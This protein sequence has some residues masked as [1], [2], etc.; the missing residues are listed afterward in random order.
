[1]W[2]Y[3]LQHHN[4]KVRPEL[5]CCF[6]IGDQ[7]GVGG[8]L[9][10]D[11]RAFAYNIGVDFR[12]PE[13][14]FLG[15]LPKNYHW[16]SFDPSKFLADLPSTKYTGSAPLI[17]KSQEII[18]MVGFPASGKSSFCKKVLIPA[19]Y[20]RVNRDE[21]KSKE[22]CIKACQMSVEEGKSVVIDNT[23]PSR[24]DRSIYIKIAKEHGIPCRCFV[25]QTTYEMAQHLN[26]FREKLTQGE[27]KRIPDIAY[28]T[29]RSKFKEPSEKEGFKEIKTIYFLPDFPDERC[30]NLFLQRNG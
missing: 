30:K 24:E 17:S 11:D 13:E 6:F 23:S 9:S 22:K 10:C 7:S 19:G 12:T 3:F 20:V 29:Y 18:V 1:M 21:L 14:I 26:I 2:E 4:G 15:E 5:E 25:M 28:N 8:S 27:C 16:T